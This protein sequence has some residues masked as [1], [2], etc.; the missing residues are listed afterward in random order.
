KS[1]Y[2]LAKYDQN[3]CEKSSQNEKPKDAKKDL[4]KDFIEKFLNRNIFNN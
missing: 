4:N 1:S 2:V 3:I